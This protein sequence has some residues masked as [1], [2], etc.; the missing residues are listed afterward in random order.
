MDASARDVSRG[1][2]QL[3]AVSRAFSVNENQVD[4]GED[5]QSTMP[6]PG[7]AP[8]DPG[9]SSA[10]YDPWT[11]GSKAACVML[12]IKVAVSGMGSMTSPGVP[13]TT[14]KPPKVVNALDPRTDKP[15]GHNLT[16][17]V[18]TL[19]YG[20]DAGDSYTSFARRLQGSPV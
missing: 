20:A 1:V 11:E 9:A 14:Y 3:D 7:Y 6:D 19:S 16:H 10:I 5:Q 4:S 17:G 12:G 2:R 13:A 8:F 18:Q 15:E